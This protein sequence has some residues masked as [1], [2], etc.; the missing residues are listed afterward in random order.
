M[1]V[2]LAE[3]KTTRKVYVGQTC[4]SLEERKYMHVYDSKYGSSLIFHRALRKYR[5]EKAECAA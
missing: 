2:Y 1:I 3:N 5:Q 4:Q